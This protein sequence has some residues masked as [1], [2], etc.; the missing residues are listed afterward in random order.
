L[1]FVIIPGAFAGTSANYIISAEVF[2]GGGT[3]E[4]VSTN[5]KVHGFMEAKAYDIKISANYRVGEG[6][7]YAGIGTLAL[8]PI[9]TS[10][11]P[12]SANNTGLVSVTIN[13]SNFLTGA[14]ASLELAG[15]YIS[16]ESITVVNIN[17][18]TCTFN[19][20]NKTTGAW[21]VVVRNADGRTGSLAGAFNITQAGGKIDVISRPINYPNPFNPDQRS[22]TIRYELSRDARI[23]LNIYNINGQRIWQQV[24]GPGSDGGKAGVN[25]V[26]W[27]GY[28]NFSQVV[29]NGIYVF[30]IESGGETLATGKIAVFR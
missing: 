25:E 8:S 13:G 1:T 21:S 20:A 4:G 29:P 19:I 15:E 22:T 14:V 26:L 9:I 16:G 10:I 24:F 18:I 6:V 2:G 12:S 23:T 30:Q 3:F 5:H 28:T 7:L 11:S 27:D 17:Q